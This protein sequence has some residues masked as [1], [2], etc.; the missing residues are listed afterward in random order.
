MS[1][2]SHGENSS[3]SCQEIECQS[4][5]VL[6]QNLLDRLRVLT[7]LTRAA[8]RVYIA[9]LI[10]SC[11]LQSYPL[12]RLSP[13]ILAIPY[14]EFKKKCPGLAADLK[15]LSVDQLEEVLEVLHEEPKGIVDIV[16]RKTSYLLQKVQ[17]KM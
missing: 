11:P 17:G 10:D 6:D 1:N 13:G 16:R 5:P 7:G 9:C 8:A 2:I 4:K 3:N 14:M 15:K 12:E